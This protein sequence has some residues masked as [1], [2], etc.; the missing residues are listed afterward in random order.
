MTWKHLLLA[1]GLPFLL[2]FSLTWAWYYRGQLAKPIILEMDRR[3][4]EDDLRRFGIV[5]HTPLPRGDGTYA[6]WWEDDYT[7]PNTRCYGTLMNW[8]PCFADEAKGMGGTPCERRIIIACDL[9]YPGE[10]LKREGLWWRPL[11]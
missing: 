8:G 11:R 1:L 4:A 6:Q 7:E 2:S 10:Y 5:S 9:L 3:E